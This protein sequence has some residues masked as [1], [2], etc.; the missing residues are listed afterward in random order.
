MFFYKAQH[1]HNTPPRTPVSRHD[2]YIRAHAHITYAHTHTHWAAC[3]FISRAY[4]C[5]HSHLQEEE[6]KKAPRHHLPQKAFILITVIA[7][8]VTTLPQLCIIQHKREQ[9]GWYSRARFRWT[10]RVCVNVAC[11]RTCPYV[12]DTSQE[13]SRMTIAALSVL[14]GFLQHKGLR[15]VRDIYNHMIFTN[16]FLN[17]INDL[18]FTSYR[19]CI[20]LSIL[21]VNERIVTFCFVDWNSMIKNLICLE[22]NIRS[23]SVNFTTLDQILDM[24]SALRVRAFYQM[25]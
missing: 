12:W 2:C 24:A 22:W 19:I 23:P 4:E 17:Y 1:E 13:T 20:I 21:N 10:H 15:H 7:T 6:K 16:I 14:T 25:I 18:A 9:T 11:V 5:V 3:K 8:C